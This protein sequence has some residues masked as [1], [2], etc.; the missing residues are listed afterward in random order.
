MKLAYRYHCAAPLD[1]SALYAEHARVRAMWDK[2]VDMDRALESAERERIGSDIPEYASLREQYE[3]LKLQLDKGDRSSVFRQ[4]RDIRSKQWKIEKQW[5]ASN[6]SFIDKQKERRF[7]QIKE[8]RQGSGCYWANYNSVVARYEA[9]RKVAKRKG[10]SMRPFDPERDD[11]MLCVQIQRTPSGLGAASDEL[12]A[13]SMLTISP[14]RKNARGRDRLTAI[15]MRVDASG[16]VVETTTLLH[17]PIP[18]CRI[19]GAQLCWRNYGLRTQWWLV[20][21]LADVLTAREPIRYDVS[22][23]LSLC[24][25]KAQSGKLLVARPSWREPYALSAEWMAG[26]DSIEKG[27]QWLDESRAAQECVAVLTPTQIRALRQDQVPLA[28][29]DWLRSWKR[30]WERVYHGRRKLLGQRTHMFREWAREIVRDVTA[31]TIDDVELDR[32]AR[33]DRGSDANSLRQRACAHRLRQEIV[34][35]ANKIRSAV[36]DTSGKVLTLQGDDKSGVW[37]RRKRAKRERSR[38]CAQPI[39]SEVA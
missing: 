8:I 3:A 22:G 32:I 36:T 16:G 5:R 27:Q 28:A 39:D 20:L 4:M 23:S 38:T 1:T 37:D 35:Q 34:H 21:Q 17:R 30:E 10:R 14:V 31:L 26:M 33:A 2:L 12:D 18:P 7:A 19:K 24:W 25:N 29:R 13:L 11:G 6:S 9:G 15:R